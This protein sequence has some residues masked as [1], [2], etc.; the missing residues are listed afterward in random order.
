MEVVSDTSF[1]QE[2]QR[3]TFK[4]IYHLEGDFHIIAPKSTHHVTS[5]VWMKIVL[6]IRAH[7]V[8][9]KKI[10]VQTPNGTT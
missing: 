9:F 4:I 3:H 1:F 10:K 5:S 6:L 7:Q 8:Q 2:L